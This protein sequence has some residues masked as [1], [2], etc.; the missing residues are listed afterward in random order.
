MD[1]VA[2]ARHLRQSQ[3]PAEAKVLQ[4]LRD[5]QLDGLKFR[6]QHQI[7]PYV[8]DFACEALKLVIE[9]DAA[10]TGM[11]RR[12]RGTI[13]AGWISNGWAGR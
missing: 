4:A 2:F 10:R 9:L 6:R 8:V 11:R 13:C 1:R 3:T 12:S 7:G 5:G